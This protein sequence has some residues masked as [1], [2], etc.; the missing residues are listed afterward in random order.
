MRLNDMRIYSQKSS[1]LSFLLKKIRAMTF[2]NDCLVA[3]CVAGMARVL[4]AG[5]YPPCP[6]ACA[7]LC[8]CCYT[9]AP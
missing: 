4:E 3:G 9:I 6:C 7:C 1:I 8:L 2:E 5:S